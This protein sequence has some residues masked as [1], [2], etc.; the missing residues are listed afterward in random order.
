M[1]TGL[2]GIDP[3]LSAILNEK[4]LEKGIVLKLAL[5][6]LHEPLP[7]NWDSPGKSIQFDRVSLTRSDFFFLLQKALEKS[8][9]PNQ[10]LSYAFNE[11]AL[12]IL[13]L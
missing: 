9:D 4:N 8:V 2:I 6:L 10:L 11:A 12:E 7:E 3:E 5:L 13:R 1:F